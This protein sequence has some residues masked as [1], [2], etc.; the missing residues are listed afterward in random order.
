VDAA[1]GIVAEV[2]VAG[3]TADSLNGM[4]GWRS[5]HPLFVPVALFYPGFH[6]T[7]P[8]MDITAFDNTIYDHWS[9]YFGCKPETVR[10]HGTTLLPERK[11]EGDRVV[12]LWYIGLHTFVQIDPAC[13][14]QL[15]SLVK[16]LPPQTAL[17]GEH[18]QSAFEEGTIL[19]HDS[20]L[21]CYLFPPDLPDYLPPAPFYLR[22]LTEADADL[23]SA[24]HAANTPADVD[25]G[26]VEVTHQAVFGCFHD[27][28]L[29]AA[30]SGYE[31]TG[32]MDIGVLT[33]PSFRKKGLGRAVVGALCAWSHQNGYLAQ[34]RHNALNTSSQKVAA[35][36]N[37]RMYFKSESFTLGNF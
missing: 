21:T 29:V 20:G 2:T 19:T 1:E 22:Q 23:M 16:T 31:R 35:S 18:I 7:L 27:R 28:E 10:Q 25:E 33:H 37:F 5:L 32:F 3:V 17:Q 15:D 11:Y 14:E 24:L 9:G 36:L 4:S 26:Y 8:N 30:A 13:F 12:A 6:V 34:Y